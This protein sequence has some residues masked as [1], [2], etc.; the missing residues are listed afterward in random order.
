[1]PGIL[2]LSQNMKR[3]PRYFGCIIFLLVWLFLISLPALAFIIATRGQIDLGNQ[4]SQYLR[5]FLLHEN[6]AE[7]LGVE[8][9][10]PFSSQPLCRQTNVHYLLWR[11][12]PQN[13]SYCQCVNVATE[14]QHPAIPGLCNP[15]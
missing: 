7:G 10:R 6:D 4:E 9:T 12:Q 11:G 3:W 2:A 8:W 5:L 13:S 1:M 14:T 15:P